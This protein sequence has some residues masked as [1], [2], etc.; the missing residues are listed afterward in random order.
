MPPSSVDDI[1]WETWQ[2]KERATLL[3][4]IRAG[5]V[6]L[7]H[8]KLGLGAGKINGP[9]GRIERGE[10]ARDAAIREVEEELL[11]TPV[12]VRK[13]GELH[14]QFVDGFSIHGSVFTASDCRGE[15]RETDE[16]IPLWAPLDAI[17]YDRMWADD[18][19]W[20]PLLL[21]GAPFRGYFI[22][23]GD[24]MLDYRIET[25]E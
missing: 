6:L 13:A 7:I 21:Q 25:S 20:L 4:V 5:S 16:A 15:P 10:S 8:K 24:R 19:H 22:F 11:T 18:R 14:F 12:D 1:N 2:P 23:D 3:F 17:P 9:G